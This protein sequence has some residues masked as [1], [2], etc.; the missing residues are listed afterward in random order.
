MTDDRPRPK[1][2]E[3]APIPPVVAAPVTPVAPVVPPVAARTATPG[4]VFVTT[5]LL[6]IGVV[7][8]VGRFSLYAD[9][10]TQLQGVYSAEGFPAFTSIALANNIGVALNI[11][12][13]VVLVGTIVAALLRIRRGRRAFWVPLVGAGIAFVIL[14]ACLLAV[15]IADPAFAQYVAT[16]TPAG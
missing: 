14:I 2:G 13:V 15:I 10:G 6:V 16:Q 4:D 3:Y 7:D 1:Y 8:V 9:L 5:L 11:A 12:R